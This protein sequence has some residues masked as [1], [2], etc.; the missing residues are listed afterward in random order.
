MG[1]ERVLGYRYMEE[2]VKKE[3][4]RGEPRW[5]WMWAARKPESRLA[6]S[7]GGRAG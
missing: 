6:G 4:E 3:S 1:L 5:W 7:R 2:R